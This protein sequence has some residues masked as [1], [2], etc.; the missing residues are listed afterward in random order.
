MF[1][2]WILKCSQHTPLFYFLKIQTPQK[3]SILRDNK[4]K[5]RIFLSHTKWNGFFFVL[6]KKNIYCSQHFLYYLHYYYWATTQSKY[7][8]L[9]LAYVLFRNVCIH[10][11]KRKWNDYFWENMTSSLEKIKSKI[12]G[13][14]MI[15]THNICLFY[16]KDTFGCY[17]YRYIYVFQ[18]TD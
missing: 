10:R 14:W 8:L 6:S 7:G 2:V 16:I 11:E 1:Q 17:I 12:Y 15:T 9:E 18:R 13:K 3:C 4:C 5:N